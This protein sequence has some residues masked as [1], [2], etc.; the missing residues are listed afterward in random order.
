MNCKWKNAPILKIYTDDSKR[1][2]SLCLC[3]HRIHLEINSYVK[4]N[5]LEKA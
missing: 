3:P 1:R 2:T 5:D 4:I